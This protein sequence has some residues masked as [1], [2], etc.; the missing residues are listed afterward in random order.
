M[1]LAC[2]LI[3]ILKK[4][5][6]KPPIA[7]SLRLNLCRLNVIVTMLDTISV[8]GAENEYSSSDPQGD[9]AT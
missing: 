8:K 5:V 3:E 7:S 4:W 6:A 2:F 1:M 9:Q